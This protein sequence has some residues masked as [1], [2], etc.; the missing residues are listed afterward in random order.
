[1]NILHILL[2]ALMGALAATGFAMLFSVPRRALAMCA[3]CGAAGVMLRIVLMQATGGAVHI[4]MATFCSALMVAILSEILS[5]RTGLP[6]TVYSVAGVIPMIPGGYMFRSVT[7]WLS[8]ASDNAEAYDLVVFSE[9]MH[10]AAMAL[11]ILAAIALGIAAP[12][13]IFYRRRP[14]A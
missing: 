4:A 14:E 10:L 5:Q 12:N 2:S 11:L 13:L 1:M 3:I 7:Y 8:I 6:P 9:S